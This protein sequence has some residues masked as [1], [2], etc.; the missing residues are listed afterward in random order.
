[1]ASL[2]F[3]FGMVPDTEKVEGADDQLRADFE[4]FKSF[5]DSNEFKHYLELEQ[6]LKSSEFAIRKK[7]ILK[8]SYKA[9]EEYRKEKRLKQMKKKLKKGMEMTDD[10]KALEKEI[11]SDAF[12][13]RI[14]YLT[15]KPKERYN[16][17][18]EAKKEE[19]YDVL[20]KS[21]KIVWYFKTK[22][23]Y[24]FKEIER[25]DET[26]NE[27]FSGSKLDLKKW[28]TRYYWGDAIL[29]DAYT[30]A[31]HKSFP[32]EGNNV[33]FYD[34]K[35][36][37]VTRKEDVD[38]KKWDNVH[39]FLEDSFEYTSAL[40]STGKSFRQKY[41]IF[42]AKIKMAPSD[43]TQAFWMV[44]EG[45]VPHIDIARYEKG[46]LW[47]NYFWKGREGSAPSKS[48]SKTG[49]SKYASD[50]FIYS[51]EWSPGKLVWKINDK[52][53]KTQSS[54]VPQ[55][56]MYMVFSTALMNWAAGTGLPSGM[57]IDWVRVYKLK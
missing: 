25:W 31:D 56:E 15:L 43:V 20:K 39:G 52:V 6:E 29:N 22:K 34:N 47:S 18:E 46:K 36:R 42:K 45:N 16:T 50:F 32:T 12:Q 11:N 49:G 44:S 23:K 54:A 9:S 5:G 30:M 26:F 17:T 24:P 7:K 19:E 57:E 2:A 28:M 10:M 27:S 1:M 37:L 8:E 38:G 51:L 33:E 4:A 53:F 13:K 14:H 41:G 3:M 48:M 21:D 55:E 35:I 40:I